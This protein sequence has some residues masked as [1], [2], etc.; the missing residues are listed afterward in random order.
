MNFEAVA[1]I[2]EYVIDG[3]NTGI[4]A[5]DDTHITY[6]P[7]DPSAWPSFSIPTDEITGVTVNRDTT[8]THNRFIGWVFAA[9]TVFMVAILYMQA[10]AG[11]ITNPEVNG[12][13]ILMGVL[14]LGG[15]TTTFEYLTR[16]SHDVI[17]IVIKTENDRHYSVY[18]RR[19][20]KEFVEACGEVI[21]SDL[22][23]VILDKNLKDAFSEREATYLSDNNLSA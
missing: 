22:E 21:G 20:N 13:T 9:V 6:S 23:T 3:E 1:Y 17:A 5:G 8:L 14:T 2:G 10:F 18:G 16:E 15:V 7:E 12:I 11:Q 19:S 4:F